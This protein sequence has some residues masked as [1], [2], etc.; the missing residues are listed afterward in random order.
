MSHPAVVKRLLA[1]FSSR[2]PIR[3][4]SLII[5][6]FGDV[7]SQHGGTLWLSSLVLGY[8]IRML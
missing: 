3:T 2:Q 5:T 8:A 4:T 7:V 6:L 1:D